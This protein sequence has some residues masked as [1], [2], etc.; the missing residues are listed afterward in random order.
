M[1]NY[2][3]PMLIKG[4][5]LDDAWEKIIQAL[6]DT[7][8][9]AIENLLVHV[10]RPT[11]QVPKELHKYESQIIS[12]STE[13]QSKK[14]EHLP[15]THGQR[16]LEWS[17]GMKGTPKFDQIRDYVVPMLLRNPRSKRAIVMVRN[18]LLDSE[19]TDDPIP[20]LTSIQFKLHKNEL[21]ATAYYRAQ[22][23]YF[24]WL[25]N[26]FELISMQHTICKQ[27]K[28]RAP[29][30]T[31]EPASITT[32]AFTGYINP[33]D[34]GRLDAAQSATLAIERFGISRMKEE[35]LRN[36][37]ESALIQGNMDKMRELRN[38]LVH[39]KQTLDRIRDVDYQGFERWQNFLQNNHERIRSEFHELPDIL[40]RVLLDLISLD[41]QLERE[42]ELAVLEKKIKSADSAMQE[43]VNI[44]AQKQGRRA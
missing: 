24:F 8:T 16:I 11:Y 17:S 41:M 4:A 1:V 29:E 44:L 34:L 5:N 2:S 33:V 43:L 15:F 6:R 23:M 27:L 22:E 26:M 10:S 28:A 3:S 18:P 40:R 9:G 19:L 31:S 32:F 30:K 7:K 14:P 37:L 25:V 21:H 35:D 38:I 42:E 13:L 20:A 39:D 12:W 36:L